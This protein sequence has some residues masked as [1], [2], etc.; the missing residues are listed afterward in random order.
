MKEFVPCCANEYLKILTFTAQR[1]L[2]LFVE[3]A[4]HHLSE[5]ER[6]ENNNRKA[7]Q[8]FE[9]SSTTIQPIYNFHQFSDGV[10][11]CLS[12]FIRIV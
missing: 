12:S 10:T 3:S 4:A 2:C 6:R 7:M 11:K 1:D 5:K 9:A 8:L